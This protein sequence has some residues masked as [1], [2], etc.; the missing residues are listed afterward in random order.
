[1]TAVRHLGRLFEELAQMLG[2]DDAE[3]LV[4]DVRLVEPQALERPLLQLGDELDAA[5]LVAVVAGELCETFRLPDAVLVRER[6]GL[7]DVASRNPVVTLR[8]ESIRAG[9][10]VS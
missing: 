4:A 2:R 8:T 3:H 9:H 7:V 6:V 10:V 5:E 1:M